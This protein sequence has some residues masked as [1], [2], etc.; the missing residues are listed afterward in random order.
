MPSV[1]NL[2]SYG[3]VLLVAA[4]FAYLLGPAMIPMFRRLKF[5]QTVRDDGPETHLQKNGTPTMGGFIF[6]IPIALVALGAA[7][8]QGSGLFEVGF[9]ILSMLLFGLV[10][11][12]DDYIK[13]VQK[14]S[15][16]L[17]AKQKI[18]LQLVFSFIVALISMYT[19]DLGAA[20]YVPFV[21]MTWELGIFYIPIVM[22][23]VIALVNSVNLTDGLDGLA[24][25]VTIIVAA[26]LAL[27]AV[28]LNNHGITLFLVAS[29]GAL[30]GFLRVN[31]FP[32]QIFMGDTGS[33]AL[34]GVV[35]AA[36]VLMNV[37]LIVP[38]LCFV[39]FME[40]VSV[41]IQVA[42]FKK[43]GK[44]FFR[45]APIHHHFEKLGWHETKVV[46]LF[47]I[48]TLVMGIASTLALI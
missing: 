1:H 8:W 14:R 36:V 3:V 27:I 11:L 6:I 38:L 48:I 9:G 19:S 44:R 25:T 20:L 10:G 18:Q 42:Y 23:V 2:G 43:T 46:R 45:M 41:I 35:S 37:E 5:G 40:S 28:K 24:S 26:C 17:R 15:L 31:R 13:V 16:G 39:Y 47:V 34:G 4:L 30:L 33:M 29:M 7:L 12:L 22:F 32:A 21:N